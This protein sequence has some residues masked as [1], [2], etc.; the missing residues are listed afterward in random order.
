MPTLLQLRQK[1]RQRANDESDP[2][3]W[4]D[5]Q[6]NGFINEAEVEVCERSRLLRDDITPA[7]CH[8]DITA[9]VG[10][11]QVHPS[12]ID[13][14]TVRLRP[15]APATQYRDDLRRRAYED[16]STW[17]VY[18]GDPDH[19]AFT[20]NES[21]DGLTGGRLLLHRFPTA[22]TVLELSCYRRP[23]APMELDTD[24]PEIPAN[25]QTR[26]LDWALFLAYDTRDADAQD[27]QRAERYAARFA[28]SFGERIP[29]DVAR[30]RLR[31]RAPK[32][33]PNNRP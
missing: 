1:C 32:V 15:I 23:L 9:G 24:E 28:A 11:Y 2:Q 27:A 22:D 19:Y 31:H 21:G 29:A 30:K 26:M 12:I 7:V 33:I 4:T 3:L 5:D 16:L 6:W 20:D 25:L 13:V 14:I 8:I 18:N 17:R 10:Q